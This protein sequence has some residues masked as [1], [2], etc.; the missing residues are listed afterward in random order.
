[1][2]QRLAFSPY[3]TKVQGSIP[4]SGPFCVESAW[5]FSGYSCSSICESCDDSGWM[6][7]S[8]RVNSIDSQKPFN[9]GVACKS[10][11]NSSVHKY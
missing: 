9:V 5:V 6:G 2:V 10:L 1:M 3:N 4:G 11:P 8:E 7:G